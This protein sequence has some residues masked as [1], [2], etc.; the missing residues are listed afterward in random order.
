MQKVLEWRNSNRIR[1]NMFTDHCITCEEHQIWFDKVNQSKSD[2]YKIFEFQ[3]RP[4]GLV[5]FTNIDRKNNRCH[6][7]FYL[8]EENLPKGT[9]LL[10]GYLG[11]KYAFEDLGIR[12]LCSEV[13]AF[14]ISSIKFHKKLGFKE[15]G[16]FS[17][18]VF[19][20][21]NYEDVILFALFDEDWSKNRLNLEG[22]L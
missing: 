19:K 12:K 20:S 18:H 7:G 21:G 2:I 5:C 9:G 11:V 15:E 10:M 13:F 3:G 14:N 6:W 1:A 22:P 4:L 17:K 16:F 8:G